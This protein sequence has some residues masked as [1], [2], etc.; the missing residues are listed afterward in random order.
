MKIILSH[1]WLFLKNRL[2]LAG[3]LFG[4][5][6]QWSHTFDDSF[7]KNWPH[8]ANV[9]A[10]FTTRPDSRPNWGN[11]M[12]SDLDKRTH[13]N[14]LIFSSYLLPLFILIGLLFVRPF[15]RFYALLCI[16]IGARTL[17]VCLT[18]PAGYFKYLYP[19]WLFAPF[20]LFLFMAERK[21]RLTKTTQPSTTL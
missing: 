17:I 19:L 14:P 11:Q 15:S 5:N 7:Y 8:F 1:P 18:A 4:F 13:Q 21:L 2:K 9:R 10:H 20:V 16:I 3:Y 12:I 6:K